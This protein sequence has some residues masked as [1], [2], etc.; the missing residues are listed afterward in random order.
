M[1]GKW[2]VAGILILILLGLCGVSLF[3][4]WQGYQMVNASGIHVN[5]ST[6]TVKA[7][8][9]EEK[10]LKVNGPV[11]LVVQTNLGDDITIQTGSDG[12][13]HILAEKTA[14]GSGEDDAQE[15]L[16]RLTI[17]TEQTGNKIKVTVQQPVE[18][19]A[20]HI[21]PVGGSVKF[22]ITVPVE[23][24]VNL[25][26]D[27]GDLNLAGTQ[28]AAVLDTSFGEVNVKD[29][30]GSLTVTT[31]NGKITAKNIQAGEYPV[32]LQ[33]DFGDVS[34]ET[35][36]A[37]DVTAKSTNGDL[38]LKNIEALGKLDVR[39]DFGG[40]E[41][42]S[43]HA[44]ALEAHTSNGKV[45]VKDADF[46]GEVNVSSD[47]GDLALEAVRSDGMDLKTQNGQVTVSGAHGKIVAHSNYGNVEVSAEDAN[48]T[49]TSDNGKIIFSGSLGEGEHTLQ[50]D[51]GDIVLTLPA[52]TALSFDLKTDFGKLKS[53]FP[54]TLSG[55]IEEKHWKGVI[56]GG[57]ALLKISTQNGNI[58]LQIS[59]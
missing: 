27:N 37:G 33:T 34:V 12:Q 5:L 8:G 41:I 10:T 54:V 3:A 52:E 26:S 59:K 4:L 42:R 50:S 25:S 6:K 32:N 17:V 58:T 43:S 51:F 24:S 16:K 47:F 35:V 39:S 46:S 23:T 44:L 53:D 21:G 38:N 1:K 30:T 28:G 29:V 20:L 7:T 13:V 15:M 57:G 45:L 9:M 19:N 49:L 31:S 55:E 56:N 2:F 18:V 40:L 11:D 22:T 36:S 48:L 14:W